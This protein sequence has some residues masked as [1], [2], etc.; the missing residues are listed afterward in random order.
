VAFD[1]AAKKAKP[2]VAQSLLQQLHGLY[3]NFGLSD[4]ASKVRK[5]IRELGAAAHSELKTI[6]TSFTIDNKKIEASLNV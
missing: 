5:R 3:R 6:S 4:E 2:I 1:A